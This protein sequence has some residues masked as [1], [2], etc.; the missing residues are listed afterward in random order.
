MAG[1]WLVVGLSVLAHTHTPPGDSSTLPLSMVL[2]ILTHRLGDCPFSRRD[3]LSSPSHGQDSSSFSSCRELEKPLLLHLIFLVHEPFMLR[4]VCMCV[5]LTDLWF[6][7]LC[8]PLSR[9]RIGSSFPFSDHLSSRCFSVEDWGSCF[10]HVFVVV[11]S[12]TL[13]VAMGYE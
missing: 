8:F 2:L 12:P 4:A 13:W 1:K 6:G 11:V 3:V 7:A 9:L 10:P 5:S